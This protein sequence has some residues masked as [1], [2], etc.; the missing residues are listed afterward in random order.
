MKKLF[1]V[2]A[3]TLYC[4]SIFVGYSIDSVDL[5]HQD[6]SESASVGQV[7]MNP[8][9]I[10]KNN[11]RTVFANLCGVVTLGT[12][13][14]VNTAI[15]GAVLGFFIRQAVFAGKDLPFI[16]KSILPQFLEYCAIC[17]SCVAGLSGLF[18]LQRKID[19]GGIFE[20]FSKLAIISQFLILIAAFMEVWG[21][22]NI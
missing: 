11:T 20:N 2:I 14:V 10:Y 4:L 3:V 16:L 19:K 6:K 7:A 17:S 1:W 9:A 5:V 12:S 18:F 8:I 22:K 15:S 13:S 21:A